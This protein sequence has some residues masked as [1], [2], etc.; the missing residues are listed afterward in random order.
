MEQH[1]LDCRTTS[2]KMPDEQKDEE[3]DTVK[4]EVARVSI[5]VPPFWSDSPEIW[6][7][8]IEA[9]FVTG[10][11][12]TDALKFNTI[13]GSI[14]SKVLT[15]V[16]DA[17]LNPPTTNKYGALKKAIIEVFG[18]SEQRKM[19]KLLSEVDLG[20][21]KPSQLMNELT[22][23]AGGKINPDFLKE[24]WLQRLPPQV[25]AI[26]STS[27]VELKQLSALADKI[28]ENGEFGSVAAITRPST[29]SAS[30]SQI[31][32][33]TKQIAEL[34]KK[35][36]NWGENRQQRSRSRNRSQTPSRRRNDEETDTLCWYHRC[37]GDRA[38]KCREPCSKHSSKINPNSGN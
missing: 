30:V 26:L 6:F 16:S 4:T 31:D 37:Y 19:K 27:D 2:F 11:I 20:D 34:T 28:M 13:V 35:F 12:S 3:A 29:S 23:L 1:Q 21:R 32:I 14:E 15:Q 22:K 17:V 36:Q 33:L 7:A 24:L 10:N 9:Q 18:D 25:R 8:Q 38:T 5:R